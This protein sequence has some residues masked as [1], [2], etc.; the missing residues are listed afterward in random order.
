M[1]VLTRKMNE[2]IQ[3]G[4]HV[5]VTILRIKGNTVRVGIEAPRDVRV[6]RGE[7]PRVIEDELPLEP[8]VPLRLEDVFGAD[9]WTADLS[10]LATS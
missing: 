3:I 2:R 7:L 10:T 1:L 9:D 8:G 6:V 4:N 5:T